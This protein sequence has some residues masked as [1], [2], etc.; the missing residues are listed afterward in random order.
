MSNTPSMSNTPMTGTFE[1]GPPTSPTRRFDRG[2][3]RRRLIQDSGLLIALIVAVIVFSLTAP[4]F[5]TEQNIL[6]VLRQASFAGIIAMGMTLVIVSAE[7]DISVGANV[8]LSSAVLGVLYANV[9]LP[10][11]LVLILVV[12]M[13]LAIGMFAGFLRAKWNLPSFIATLA[14]FLGL[15][16]LAEVI[17]QQR[18][19][20][21]SDPLMTFLNSNPLGLPLP[22]W[23]LII[24][25]LA[26]WFVT[27]RTSFGRTVYA[28]GG[29]ASAARLAGLKVDRT[30]I[31]VFA[32]TGTLAA[33][34]G[35]L[36]TARISSSTAVIGNGLEF[37]VIAAVIIGGTS[38]M[39]GRGSVVGTL[40]GVLFVTVLGN[41][42]VLYGVSSPAQNIVRGAIV[43]IAVLLTNVQTGLIR[44]KN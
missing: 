28:V 5:A 41:A 34:V 21:V 6:N 2:D 18:T 44:Q 40:L 1:S 27:T 20:P 30:R 24:T 42:L 4:N 17:S 16:G 38:L 23:L 3:L 25:F 35:I 43:V 10:M 36:F 22:T 39:G 32:I 15:R 8:A 31:A 33:I 12:L 11:W 7:I 13:G 19:I 9:G 14:L 37:E 26:A 29:N